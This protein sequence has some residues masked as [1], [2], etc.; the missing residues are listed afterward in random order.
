MQNKKLFKNWKVNIL[1][2]K[3]NLGIV[4]KKIKNK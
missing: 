2:E 3:S 4:N 1:N